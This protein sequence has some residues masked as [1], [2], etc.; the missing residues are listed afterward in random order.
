MEPQCSVP[1]NVVKNHGTVVVNA[2][3]PRTSAPALPTGGGKAGAQPQPGAPAPAAGQPEDGHAAGGS[4]A[5]TG[6]PAADPTEGTAQPDGAGIP[7]AGNPGTTVAAPGDGQGNPVAVQPIV[8]AEPLRKGVTGLLAL[9]AAV[10]LFGVG[11]AV[12][13]TIVAQRGARPAVA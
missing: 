7:A 3:A 11:A 12:I 9:I 10:L 6:S 4:A 8:K 13:R 2:V 5:P 1:L